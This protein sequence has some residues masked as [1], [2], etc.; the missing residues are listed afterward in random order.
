[1]AALVVA[2]GGG[3]EATPLD[4]RSYRWSIDVTF[5]DGGVA[6]TEL[7]AF[8][9][10]DNNAG[11][12]V[13]SLTLVGRPE[14]VGD[15]EGTAEFVTVG[16]TTVSLGLA[17]I[18]GGAAADLDPASYYDFSIFDEG[19]LDGFFPNASI[20]VENVEAMFG[21]DLV[22]VGSEAI[23]GIDARRSQAEFNADDLNRNDQNNLLEFAGQFGPTTL[24]VWNDADGVVLRIVTTGSVDNSRTELNYFGHG[25]DMKIAFPDEVLEMP[26]IPGWTDEE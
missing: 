19:G 9:R 16:G 18:M 6:Q 4:T 12:N 7:E 22:D 13:M 1:M 15:V 5:A 8:G 17:A 2:C 14:A 23:G 10:V 3:E 21:V 26:A 11:A 24:E 25:E 20:R